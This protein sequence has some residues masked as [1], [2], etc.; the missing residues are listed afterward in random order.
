MIVH[1]VKQEMLAEEQ[2]KDFVLSSETNIYVLNERPK[3]QFRID[4]AFHEI[5]KS[6]IKS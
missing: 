1:N 4:G 5:S 3:G 6:T 2:L